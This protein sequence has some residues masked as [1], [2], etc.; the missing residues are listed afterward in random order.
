MINNLSI[1]VLIFYTLMLI[2]LSVD[3]ILLP[4]YVNCSINFRGF[5]I[6]VEIR[7]YTLSNTLY[8]YIYI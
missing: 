2:S 4:K 8:I 5:P 6:N 1:V 3:E 7:S